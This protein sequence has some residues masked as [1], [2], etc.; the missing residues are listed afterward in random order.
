[1]AAHVVRQRDSIFVFKSAYEPGSAECEV[2]GRHL[3]AHGDGV[4]DVAFTVE[5]LDGIM[6]KC[7]E[8]GVKVVREIWEEEDHGGKVRF[9]TVQVQWVVYRM[10]TILANGV[11][12]D[13]H[14]L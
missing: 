2:M 11:Q 9:A 10:S 14:F 8:R 12:S 3:V 13:G 1:M 7:R 5:D 6:A 4:K